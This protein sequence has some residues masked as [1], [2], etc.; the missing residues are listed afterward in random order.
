METLRIVRYQREE[1]HHDAEVCEGTLLTF[2]YDIPYLGGCGVF[3]PLQIINDMFS[4]GHNGGGMSPGT[5]WEPFLLS[6]DE[7]DKLIAAVKSTPLEQ[8]RPYARFAF[9]PWKFDPSFDH[10]STRAEWLSAVCRKH[11]HS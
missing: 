11:L 10:I 1:F 7:Y 3:P 2:V 5:K 8:I 9:V 6:Q 4:R